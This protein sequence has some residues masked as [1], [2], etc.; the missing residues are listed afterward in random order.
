MV[1]PGSLWSLS[2]PSCPA[3]K[4]KPRYRGTGCI[5][6][7]GVQSVS[8]IQGYKVYQRYRGTGCIKDTRVEGE[9]KIQGYRGTGCIKDT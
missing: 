7:T 5:R 4:R 8:K 6:D 3:V 9:S 2:V 1:D